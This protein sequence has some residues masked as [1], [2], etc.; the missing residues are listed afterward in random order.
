MFNAGLK[1][2]TDE[3]IEAM[4]DWIEAQLMAGAEIKG[5]SLDTIIDDVID[6]GGKL[7]NALKDSYNT[8]LM[9]F[10]E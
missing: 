9:S 5:H 7:H 3:A 1:A 6:R 8:G 2:C 4:A 10:M